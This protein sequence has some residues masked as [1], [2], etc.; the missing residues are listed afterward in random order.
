MWMPESASSIPSS[1]P[2]VTPVV[3]T[4]MF[5]SGLHG[6]FHTQGPGQGL[7][8]VRDFLDVKGWGDTPTLI[9]HCPLTTFALYLIQDFAN[10]KYRLDALPT[11]FVGFLGS[12]LNF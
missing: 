3:E 5:S 2:P 6:H 11:K 7:P 4:L 10:P 9:L 8:I 1:Q 12:F